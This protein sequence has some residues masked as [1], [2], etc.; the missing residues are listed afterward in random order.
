MSKEKDKFELFS[1][2][3]AMGFSYDE[4]AQL[5]R[6]EMTL[7]QWSEQACG[8]SDNYKS[9]AIERDP[10]TEKPSMVVHPYDG[11]TYSYAIADREA[12]ALKRLA[13]IMAKHPDFVSYHQNDPRGCALY[14][15]SKK[16]VSGPLECCYTR[17]LA[18]CA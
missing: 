15:V 4:A 5:R 6:I 17:G 9:W 18:I 16:D 14:I 7:Q 2:L 11:K 8:N 3:E 12:G 1:R 10:K 13:A